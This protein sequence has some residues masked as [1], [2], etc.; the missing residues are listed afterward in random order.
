MAELGYAAD[1]LEALAGAG[2]VW[3]DEGLE[4]AKAKR[5]ATNASG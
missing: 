1:E 2:I 4:A 3:S 5:K